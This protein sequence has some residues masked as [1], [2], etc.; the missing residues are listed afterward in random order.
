MQP[1]LFSV[2]VPAHN[3]AHQIGPTLAS[4]VA[5][6]CADW[7]CI[8][9]DDGSDA[10]DALRGVVDAIGDTRFR[11]LRR[12]N[13]G[14]G[15]ARNS[16]IDAARG[17]FVAFLDSDDLFLPA[18]LS[19]MAAA[20][21][22][23]PDT[24]FYAPVLVDRGVGRHWVKPSRPLGR[25][26]DVG[27]YLFVHNEVIQTSSLVLARDAAARVRFDPGLRKGQDL[28]FCL[29]LQRDGVPIRMLATP[30]TV[31]NDMA[32]AGRTSRTPGYAAPLAWLKQSRPLLSA[33]GAPRLSGDGAGLLH[34]KAAPAD[35]CVR[36]RARLGGGGAGAGRAAPGVAGVSAARRV[37]LAGRSHGRRARGIDSVASA[38]VGTGA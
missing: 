6:D 9:V 22:D 12:A 27:D 25:H 16:G 1:P 32:E 20:L 24:A 23:A 18:K 38:P 8:V 29:R 5:Q 13:G 31:W 21:T 36:P 26:E 30:L 2:I 33:R 37:S 17:R 35:R 3:R 19:T 28:D 14:G 4:V 34:G 7:E 11:Y 15:A 10:D